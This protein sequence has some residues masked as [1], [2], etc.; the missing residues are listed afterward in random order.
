MIE[1][2][3]SDYR[4]AAIMHGD[5]IMSGDSKKANQAFDSLQDVLNK[6]TEIGEDQALLEL[7]SDENVWVQLWAAA[8]SLETDEHN[9]KMKLQSL[10]NAGIPIASMDARYTLQEW[11]NGS[12]KFRS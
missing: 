6:L 10:A 3:I 1:D 12:L 7:L 2:L 4:D 9:A 11:D 8:H 5:G